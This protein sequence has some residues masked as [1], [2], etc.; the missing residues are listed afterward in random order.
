MVLAGKIDEI[1]ITDKMLMSLRELTNSAESKRI[2]FLTVPYAYHK[3]Y[4]SMRGCRHLVCDP[5]SLHPW[6]IRKL[7]S[8]GLRGVF[9]F[10][11]IG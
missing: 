1:F 10:V 5:S 6:R 4:Y 9:D 8:L 2:R 3:E 11:G 7:A